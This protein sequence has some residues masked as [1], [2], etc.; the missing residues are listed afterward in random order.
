MHSFSAFY[1]L[2]VIEE[3]VWKIN[4]KALKNKD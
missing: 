2:N 1:F 3:N 4:L